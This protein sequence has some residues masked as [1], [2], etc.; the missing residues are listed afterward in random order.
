MK[1]FSLKSEIILHFLCLFFIS[2]K[3]PVLK[4]F[5]FTLFSN[6]ILNDRIL[7]LGKP[8]HSSS[9]SRSRRSFNYRTPWASSPQ[10]QYRWQWV[11]RPPYQPS[12]HP[13][14]DSLPEE[15]TRSL[16]CSLSPPNTKILSSSQPK[17]KPK[18]SSE[19]SETKPTLSFLL[20]LLLLLPRHFSKV[21]RRC[22]R[23]RSPVVW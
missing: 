5:V 21:A 15:E 19:T 16:S 13:Q 23:E 7:S 2:S 9:S 3:L 6:S 20:L 11:R 4:I 12:Q 10:S 18:L 14:H 22:R 1:S 17:T 8:P